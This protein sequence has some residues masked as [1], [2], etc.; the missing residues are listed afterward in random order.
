MSAG[1]KVSKIEKQRYYFSKK[2]CMLLG[3]VRGFAKSVCFVYL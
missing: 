1:E 2:S 3:G